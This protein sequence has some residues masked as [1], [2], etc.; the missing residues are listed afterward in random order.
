MRLQPRHISTFQ[1]FIVCNDVCGRSSEV[2]ATS[3]R[4]GIGRIP[5]ENKRYCCYYRCGA[6]LLSL[7][8]ALARGKW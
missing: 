3:T 1:L 8:I 2:V 5:S 6:L 4:R 7:F